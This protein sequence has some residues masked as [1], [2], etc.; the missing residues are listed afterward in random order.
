MFCERTLNRH[1]N[2]LHERTLRIAYEDFES[3]FKELLIKDDSVT[4][5]SEIYEYCL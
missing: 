3:S 2:R 4:I 1:I 5:T